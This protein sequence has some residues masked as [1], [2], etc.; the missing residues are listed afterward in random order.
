MEIKP[1]A[2]GGDWIDFSM[3][4]FGTDVSMVRLFQK[5]LFQNRLTSCAN[6]HQKLALWLKTE[7]L[8]HTEETPEL[9]AVLVY[10][11]YSL[12]DLE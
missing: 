3:Q 4:S 7:A 1:P 2:G 6:F 8:I 9:N 11:L 12:G 10:S 5:L